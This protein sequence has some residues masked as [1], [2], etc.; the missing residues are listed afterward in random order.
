M[1]SINSHLQRGDAKFF[2]LTT[3]DEA[4]IPAKQDPEC[5]HLSRRSLTKCRSLWAVVE[6]QSEHGGCLFRLGAVSGTTF[7]SGDL[8]QI[9]RKFRW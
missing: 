1:A 8:L 5:S 6:R 7:G 2:N 4:T 3:L 9:S